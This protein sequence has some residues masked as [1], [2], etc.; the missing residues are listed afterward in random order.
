MYSPDL[1]CSD[2]NH[3]GKYDLMIIKNG[4]TIYSTSSNSLKWSEETRSKFRGLKNGDIVLIY[5]IVF[6]IEEDYFPADPLTLLVKI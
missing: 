2:I 1:L 3:T 5:N 6:Q 4:K